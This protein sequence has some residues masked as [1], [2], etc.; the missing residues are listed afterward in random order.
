MFTRRFLAGLLPAAA[1][2]MVFLASPGAASENPDPRIVAQVTRYLKAIQFGETFL[3]GVRKANSAEGQG[4]AFLDRVLMASP[5]EIEATVAPAFAG[6]VS[7]KDA[8]AM[9]DFFAG[10]VGQKAISQGQ[11]QL[12]SAE[13]RELE[14]F[15]ETPAGQLSV[16]LTTDPAIRQEYFVLLKAKYG[17]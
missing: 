10:P 16:T 14:K 3:G 7:L 8:R 17:Q 4:S 13:T 6:H 11:K 9:A 5:E 2:F 12:S 1:V 15:G